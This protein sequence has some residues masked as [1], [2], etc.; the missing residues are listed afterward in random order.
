MGRAH[1]SRGCL[2]IGLELSFIVV[3]FPRPVS[4]M[5]NQLKCFGMFL[6]CAPPLQSPVHPHQISLPFSSR[7]SMHMEV[8]FLYSF[9]SF[10][11][12]LNFLQYVPS[13]VSLPKVR[14]S[15]ILLSLIFLIVHGT[16]PKHSLSVC[17]GLCGLSPLI[18]SAAHLSARLTHRAAQ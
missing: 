4:F 14:S 8:L 17:A 18:N 7:T 15:V 5:K 16:L 9:I 6:T 10:S 13:E 3:F 2:L 11:F 1:L 12:L